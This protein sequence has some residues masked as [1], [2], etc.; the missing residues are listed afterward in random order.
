MVIFLCMPD[1]LDAT[2]ISPAY[3][4]RIRNHT[5]KVVKASAESYG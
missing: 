5:H 3:N 1:C 2:K 4:D